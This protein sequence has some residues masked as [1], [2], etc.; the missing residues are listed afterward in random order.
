MSHRMTR[1]A[2]AGT[3]IVLQ[4]FFP[5]VSDAGPI[6]DWLFGRRQTT[7]YALYCP[8]T[9]ACS[10]VTASPCSPCGQAATAYSPVMQTQA[11]VA[12]PTVVNYAPQTYQTVQAQVPHTYYRP[13]TA[14]SPVAAAPTSTMAGCTL[15]QVQTQR[16]PVGLF[17]WLFGARQPVSP[18]P[19]NVQYP[20]TTT[21]YAATGVAAPSY[22]APSMQYAAPS[23]QYAAPSYGV[24]AAGNCQGCSGSSTFPT[25]PSAPVNPGSSILSAPPAATYPAPSGSPGGA[26]TSPAPTPADQPPSLNAPPQGN[27]QG[28]PGQQNSYQGSSYRAAPATPITPPQHLDG[29][30]PQDDARPAAPQ[31]NSLQLIPYPGD[32][33]PAPESSAPRQ[34]N[35][36]GRTASLRQSEPWSFSLISWET[37]E[38]RPAA[39]VEP[40][41]APTTPAQVWDDTG[42]RSAR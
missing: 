23:M 2:L 38:T 13:T 12:A 27:Y 1:G 18:H 21:G 35:H 15:V 30:A 14:F 6:L 32:D 29:P 8:T 33:Q 31:P 25:I 11:T 20:T 24:P 37:N 17:G 22:A 26:T 3:L 19:I 36:R 28:Y 39:A 41:P 4:G 16:R 7:Q 10:P 5:A 42:W 40:T 34:L 9:T